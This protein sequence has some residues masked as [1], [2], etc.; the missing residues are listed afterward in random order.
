LHANHFYPVGNTTTVTSGSTPGSFTVRATAG[1]LTQD[2]TITIEDCISVEDIEKNT[3]FVAKFG[4][5]GCWM[6]QNLRTKTYANGTTLVLSSNTS[7]TSKSYHYPN[8]NEQIFIDHPEYGLL[9]TWSAVSDRT[10]HIDEEA[11]NANQEQHQGICPNGWH[12]PSD[13]EWNELEE[14]IAKSAAGV[15]STEGTVTWESG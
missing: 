14:K 3:Y 9:Y 4:A 10:D 12:L 15:Y 11:N 8:G 7:S 6:T 5:A 13:Y 2:C 1:G